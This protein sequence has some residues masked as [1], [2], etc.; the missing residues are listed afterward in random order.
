MEQKQG[1][2][3]KTGK[4][5]IANPTL[6]TML[7]LFEQIT[8]EAASKSGIEYSNFVKACKMRK[9]LRMSTY[10][11]CASGF[12]KDVYVVKP[13]CTTANIVIYSVVSF[14]YSQ[15]FFC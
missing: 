7:R 4:L 5:I 2:P 14:F 6:E 10:L 9:D 15:K 3:S 13:K 11:K 12:D 1:T 8:K